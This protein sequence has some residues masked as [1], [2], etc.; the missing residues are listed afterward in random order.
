MP[1]VTGANHHQDLYREENLN[2][3]EFLPKTKKL[4]IQKFVEEQQEEKNSKT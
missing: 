4:K 3:S 2:F 1:K